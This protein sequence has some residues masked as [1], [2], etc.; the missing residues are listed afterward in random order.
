MA[1]AEKMNENKTHEHHI[2]AEARDHFRAAREEMRKSLE[3]ML[4]PEFKEHRHQ[5]HREM[6]LGWRSMIDT[7]LQRM[8][9]PTKKS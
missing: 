4:P 9:T 5:A 3:G 1:M 6:L 7:A 2:P 8:E